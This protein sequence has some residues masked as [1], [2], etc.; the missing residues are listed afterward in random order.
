MKKFYAIARKAAFIGV[1]AFAINVAPANAGSVAGTGGSTEV[2]QILNN[3]ELIQQNITQAKQLESQ[4]KQAMTL[5]GIPWIQKSQLLQ[6]LGQVV[7]KGMAIGYEMGGFE[8]RFSS[9]YRDYRS[10]NAFKQAYGKWS[11]TTRDSIMSAMKANGMNMQDFATESSM[12]DNL[13]SMS[14][15]ATGQMQAIQAG[16]AIAH[17]M[18]NQFQSLRG[19]MAAQNQAHNAY[20][21]QK[22]AQD[23][24]QTTSLNDYGNN[25]TFTAMPKPKTKKP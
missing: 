6:Q 3:M 21:A 23:E 16:N 13:R 25:G 8:D 12:L 10:G 18:V 1:T 5:P 2:T 19:M 15:N 11:N 24:A 22:T 4:L 17:A 14:D 20:M 7:N 9:L